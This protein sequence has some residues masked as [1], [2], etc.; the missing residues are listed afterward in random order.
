MDFDCSDSA[1]LSCRAA[2][3]GN[4]IGA[5]QFYHRRRPP[6]LCVVFENV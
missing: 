3:G 5:G 6:K 2:A 1:A 4:R